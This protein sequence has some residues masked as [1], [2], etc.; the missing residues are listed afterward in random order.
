[1]PERN[2]RPP[3]EVKKAIDP[4]ADTVGVPYPE[5]PLAPED[6]EVWFEGR[7][8]IFERMKQQEKGAVEELKQRFKKVE[9][10]VAFDALVAELQ[11]AAKALGGDTVAVRNFTVMSPAG[12]EHDV[13]IIIKPRR[14]IVQK[15]EPVVYGALVSK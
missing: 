14:E 2:E 12:E 13:A 7:N 9:D 5:R 15:D 8:K 11:A 10:Q 3:V 1:M 4:Y 6:M